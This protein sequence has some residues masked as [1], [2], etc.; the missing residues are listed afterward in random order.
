MGK[1]ILI[2]EEQNVRTNIFPHIYLPCVDA[3]GHIV[4]KEFNFNL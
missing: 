4:H 1:Q 3:R 2:V